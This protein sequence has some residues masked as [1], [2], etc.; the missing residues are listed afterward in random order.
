MIVLAVV[1]AAI[2]WGERPSDRKSSPS[3]ARSSALLTLFDQPRPVPSLHFQN[4]AAH[5]M[6][7]A[8]FRGRVL[9]VNIWATWCTPCRKEMPSL[10]RLQARLGGP[11]FRVVA[12]A[13]DRAGCLATPSAPGH[14]TA[15]P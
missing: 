1:V 15:K 8:D 14:G 12:I 13:Q 9:L 6:T 2:A 3:G 4:A 11:D 10:D 5:A 7:L